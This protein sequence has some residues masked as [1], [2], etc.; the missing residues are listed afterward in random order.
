MHGAHVVNAKVQGAALIVQDV[1]HEVIVHSI[2][3]DQGV[4]IVT[5]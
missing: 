5:A 2:P 4:T 1:N 3:N